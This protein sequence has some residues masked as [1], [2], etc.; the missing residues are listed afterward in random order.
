MTDPDQLSRP[1][2]TS[3]WP[4]ADQV[5]DQPAGS[6]WL[7]IVEA[8]AALGMTENA[9][10]NRIKRRTL[11]SRKGN[12]G[13]ILVLVDQSMLHGRPVAGQPVAN[14]SDPALELRAT[15]TAAQAENARLKAERDGANARLEDRAAELER[16]R[17]D[18]TA[19]LDQTRA[20]HRAEAERLRADHQAEL[21]RL[22]RIIDRLT[23][24]WWRK[25]FGE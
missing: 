19:A 16:L 20:D 6:S 15:L 13:R 12:N 24:P 18:Y 4:A 7:P 9:V 2:P 21:A 1:K 5:T 8:A 10:R 17:A 25:W 22:Q 14:H 23:A 11:R 3:L